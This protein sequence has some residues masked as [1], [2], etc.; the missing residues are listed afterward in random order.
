VVKLE[1]QDNSEEKTAIFFRMEKAVIQ[2]R[3][4]WGQERGTGKGDRISL[5]AFK[6]LFACVY[7]GCG[8]DFDALE[9]ESIHI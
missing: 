3:A 1:K 9:H 6:S 8:L 2:W 4:S 5:P 7:S